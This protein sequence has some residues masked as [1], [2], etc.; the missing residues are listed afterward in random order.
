METR[1]NFIS[2]LL[3][4]C[5][6]Y[7]PPVTH[8]PSSRKTLERL[9]LQ[10]DVLEYHCQNNK[11]IKVVKETKNG[12]KINTD[13]LSIRLTFENNTEHL[14]PTISETGKRYSNIK[15]QWSIRQKE[16]TLIETTGKTL[17]EHCV[18]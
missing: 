6:Q 4:A 12:K 10:N 17:A 7:A 8:H 9:M 16:A 5:Q 15:W 2:L 3:T 18:P 13:Q 14:I 11:T 1:A